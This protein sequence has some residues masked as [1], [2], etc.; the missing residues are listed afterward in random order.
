VGRPELGTLRP[1]TPA[2]I[3][4]VDRQLAVLRTLVGGVEVFDG[5]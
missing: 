2:D 3:V 1:G 4:V 5:G